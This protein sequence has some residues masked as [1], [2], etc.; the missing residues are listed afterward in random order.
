MLRR[1]LTI[2]KLSFSAFFHKLRHDLAKEVVVLLSSLIILATFFYVFNDFLNVEVASLSGAMRVAFAK[3]TTVIT[4]AGCTGLSAHLI[5]NERTGNQTLTAFAKAFGEEE[6]VLRTYAALHAG[7]CLAVLHGLGWWVSQRWLFHLE[8]RTCLGVEGLM[9]VVS[10]L[11]ALRKR[12]HRIEKDVLPIL[13]PALIH[14]KTPDVSKTLV[15]WRLTQII[16][17]HK[18]ARLCLVLATLLLCPI[19]WSGL[20]GIPPFVAA[21]S[22]LA[23]GYVASLSLLFFVAEDLE[24]AWTERGAG[25]SHADFVRAYERLSWIIGGAFAGLAG[26]VYLLAIFG[27]GSVAGGSMPFAL[28]IAPLSLAHTGK[29]FLITLLPSLTVPW[30]MFQIDAKRPGI[31]ALVTLLCSL[32]VGTAILATWL[33]ILLL[34]LL[35]YY[36]LQSQNGRYYRA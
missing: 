34:P 27:A 31:T 33:G 24:Q 21:V 19:V 18:L 35:R 10:C 9:I 5:R 1:S 3:V 8:W 30:L 28:E 14:K 16:R 32:F 25:V 20:R 26:M 22:G 12:A 4:L 29:V 2:F 11:F 15:I 13:S 7:T 36:A 17:R 23:A 6:A